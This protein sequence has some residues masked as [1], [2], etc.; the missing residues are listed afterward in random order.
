MTFKGTGGGTDGEPGGVDGF[1]MR[2][3]EGH[4]TRAPV[5]PWGSPGHR[6]AR[7]GW[8]GEQSKE[9]TEGKDTLEMHCEKTASQSPGRARGAVAWKEAAPEEGLIHPT[10]R[11]GEAEAHGAQSEPWSRGRKLP[12]TRASSKVRLH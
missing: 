11:M 6:E 1:Q 8:P 12:G 5:G 7:H 10:T 2:K 4:T 9:G 3:S